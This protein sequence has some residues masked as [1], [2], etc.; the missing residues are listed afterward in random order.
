MSRGVETA[1]FDPEAESSQ[2]GDAGSISSGAPP[3]QARESGTDQTSSLPALRVTESARLTVGRLVDDPSLSLVEVFQR[4]CEIAADTLEVE[5]V[6]IWLMSEDRQ[7]LRCVNLFERSRREHSAGPC[8]PTA[9]FPIYLSAIRERRVLPC[10]HVQTDPRAIELRDIYLVPLGITSM[11]GA[12]IHWGEE[13]IG[14]VCH[15]HVGPPRE[16]STEDRDFAMSVADAAGFR[17]KLAQGQLI[18]AMVWNRAEALPEGD[19]YSLVGRLAAG[20]AHDFRNLLTVIMGNAALITQR[21][22]VPAEVIQR[23]EQILEAGERGAQLI[24]Q[25][26]E[27][28]REPTGQPRPVSLSEVLKRLLPL[29]Q[30]GVGKHYPI[31]FQAAPDQD[32]IW[33]DP[34]HL[35]RVVMNLVLNAREAMPRGGTIT[36]QVRVEH[37]SRGQ[38]PAGCYVCLEVRDSGVGIAPE[39]LPR[40]FEPGFTTKTNGMDRGLGLAIVRRLVERAGGFIR[41]ESQPGSGS[42]FRVYWPR[43]TGHALSRSGGSEEN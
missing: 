2:V 18:Q 4:I 10:E 5:R 20:V 29:L 31:E 38:G 1:D 42:V 12:P 24:R 13:V 33:I 17:L 21:N 22:D 40:V 16:W 39:H 15:E 35:E 8:L 25:L 34:S 30:T 28:G 11:L 36:I 7:Q 26:L 43:V 37:S 32:W 9:E 6:S 14:V 3:S 23:A 27:F 41:V 19:R